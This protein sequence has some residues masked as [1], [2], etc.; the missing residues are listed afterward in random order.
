MSKLKYDLDGI[1]SKLKERGIDLSNIDGI[2]NVIE[3]TYPK[4]DKGVCLYLI[5]VITGDI[6][7]D[8]KKYKDDDIFEK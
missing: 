5:D 1:M 6:D 7:E 3:E 8:D 2:G 4:I